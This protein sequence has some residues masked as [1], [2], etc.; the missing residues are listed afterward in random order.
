MLVLR[1][2]EGQWLEVT[3]EASGD[4]LRLRVCDLTSHRVNLVFDE[5]ARRFRI[6]RSERRQR[7]EPA[8]PYSQ[9]M[10]DT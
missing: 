6:E 4:V 10:I 3:H 2:T 8:I 5:P 7:P 9:S 1:R